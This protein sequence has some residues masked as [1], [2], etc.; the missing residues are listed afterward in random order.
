MADTPSMTPFLS[1]CLIVKN[2]A[3]DLPR[4]LQSLEAVVDETVVLDTGSTDGTPDVARR[5]GA[6]VVQRPWSHDFADARN[7]ALAVARGKWVLVVD[8]DEELDPPSAR[9]LRERLERE[10][11]D[12]YRL[13]VRNL[14]PPGSL[15]RWRDMHLT[16]L[17]RRDPAHRYEGRIHE[18]V[19]PS[20]LA[21]GGTI[22]ETDLVIIHYGYTVPEAQGASR[23]ER[24]L[25][26]LDAMAQVHPKDAYVQ[27][28]LGAT[29]MAI[30]RP[31][32]A[33]RAL[34]RAMELDQGTLGAEG[35]A[36]CE[37]KLAQLALGSSDDARALAH[38]ENTLRR[39]P[40]DAL[41]LYVAGVAA[42][43]L[44][45]MHQAEDALARLLTREDISE[46]QRRDIE[47]LLHACR[48]RV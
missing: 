11:A 43:G 18:Q 28:Q 30:G 22:A 17:F 29:W 34:T 35:R 20:I 9:R 26:L 6:N 46:R 5:L 32:E 45:R 44:G 39:S 24:N 37:L 19:A 12:G 36:E 8:A 48:T 38:A 4:C 14:Q 2:E 33:R 41:A 3:R 47:A 31:H 7:A 23:A 27:F 21:S 10:D 15:L 40:E 1:A 13:I 16:R 25:G 42:F